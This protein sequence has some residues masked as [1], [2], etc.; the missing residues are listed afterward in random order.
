MLPSMPVKN[1]VNSMNPCGRER[2][3]FHNFASHLHMGVVLW[4][5]CVCVYVC[6]CVF[7]RVHACVRMRRH[8]HENKY[9]IL[10]V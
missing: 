6:V 4:R 9:F 10:K 1:D 5:V 2:A 8:T 7:V 3:D